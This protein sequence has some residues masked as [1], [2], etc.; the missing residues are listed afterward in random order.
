M[1]Q[2]RI[3]FV[4]SCIVHYVKGTTHH[5]LQLH[6][7]ST[8]DLIAY[9]D[10]NWIGCHDIRHSTTGYAIFFCAN[11][12][13][14]SF[15]KQNIISH[16]SAEAQKPNIAGAE[17]EFRSSDIAWLVQLLWEL[18]VTLSASPRIL[19]NN[20]SAIFMAINPVTHPQ[21]KHIAIDF[22]TY[23]N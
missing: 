19:C 23:Y 17:A 6:K 20:Q 7:Q 10:A 22:Q 9:F 16:S 21:L 3:I 8:H 12:I 18:H 11:L 1:L 5:G 13:S 4:L 2:L 15:K 14:W